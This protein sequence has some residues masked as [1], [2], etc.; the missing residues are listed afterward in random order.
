MLKRTVPTPVNGCPWMGSGPGRARRPADSPWRRSG[1]VE[2]GSENAIALSQL[3]A[4]DSK[5]PLVGFSLT[6]SPVSGPTTAVASF[7]R[8]RQPAGYE[9]PR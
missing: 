9:E 5:C 3:R 7:V 1:R 2:V 6:T 8:R 4:S